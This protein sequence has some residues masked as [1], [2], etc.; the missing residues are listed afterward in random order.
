MIVVGWA[1]SIGL[2]DLPFSHWTHVRLK[3]SVHTRVVMAKCA[4]WTW[5]HRPECK[6]F[7]RVIDQSAHLFL[8][9]STR[10]ST[11]LRGIDQC[12]HFLLGLFMSVHI[13]SMPV[14]QIVSRVHRDNFFDGWSSVHSFQLPSAPEISDPGSALRV[15][16]GVQEGEGGGVKDSFPVNA[17]VLY[18]GQTAQRRRCCSRRRH[19][20]RRRRRRGSRLMRAP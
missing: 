20:H 14:I 18:F 12:A 8:G 4:L 10:V 3:H 17:R 7:L 19:H 13:F 9:S 15:L 16:A 2:I 1:L 11:F 5:G 6:L